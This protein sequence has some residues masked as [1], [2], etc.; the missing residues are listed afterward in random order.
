MMRERQDSRKA[1]IDEVARTSETLTGRGGLALVSRYLR[2]IELLPELERVFGSLRRSRKGQPIRTLFHQLICFF[3]D[4]TSRHL[5]RFDELREDAG[6]AGAIETARE[7]M[8]SSH[9][10]KRF[11]QAFCGVQCWLFRRVLQQLFLWRV[12]RGQPG[13]IVL[14]IDAMVM[15]NSEADQRE[16]VQ[17]TYKKGVKGFAP[18]QITWERFVIDAVFRGGSKHSNADRTVGQAIGHLV[19]FLRRH[20]RADVAIVLRMDSGFFD[21]KLF[22]LCEELGIGYVCGGRLYDELQATVAPAEAAQWASY[23]NGKQAWQ[24]FEFADQRRSWRQARRA[25]Y[26]RPVYEEEQCLLQFARPET[27]LYTNLGC[28][29]LIDGLLAGEGCGD[30]TRPQRIIELYHDRGA[31]ELVHRALKDFATE[32][33]PF[34][35]FA[36]NAA[37][38]YTMLVAF[39]VYESF[40]EDVTAPVVPVTAYPTRVRRVALDFAAKIVRTG[41]RTILKVTTATWHQLRIPELW[42]RTAHPPRFAWG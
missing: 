38:Y 27:V 8:V 36:A 15:D 42:E 32:A 40:K 6:Y 22:A 1:I 37:F 2:G 9:M 23:R 11:F 25:L 24:Y 31:D 20:Y 26:L 33:L 35:R 30:W 14:G 12:K 18:L 7:Q 4:G 34:Q 21:Q 10:V 39:F 29:E 16:G 28:G 3:V 19:T 41:G 17:P 13:V 5:V